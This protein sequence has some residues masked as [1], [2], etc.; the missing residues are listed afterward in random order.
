MTNEAGSPSRLDWGLLVLRVVIG[1]IFAAHG[2]QKVFEFTLA[3]TIDSFGAMGVPGAGFV[4]P[5]IALL[6][7]GGGV[8]LMLGAL[9]RIVAALLVLDM[10][11]AIVIVHASAGFWVDNGGVEFVAALGASALAL[12][13]TGAGRIAVDAMLAKRSI[14]SGELK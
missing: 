3:G 4:A 11:G 13:L 6:E 9:T 8:L 2:F 10:V 12:A 7:L 1:G 5:A 14:G